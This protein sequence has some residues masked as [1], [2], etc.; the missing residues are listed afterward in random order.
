MKSLFK[1]RKYTE[2]QKEYRRECILCNKRQMFVISLMKKPSRNLQQP[3][4][5]L[6]VHSYIYNT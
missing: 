5:S 2:L 6:T 1:K 4:I 3:P